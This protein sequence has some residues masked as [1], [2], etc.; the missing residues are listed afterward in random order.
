MRMAVKL[1]RAPPGLRPDSHGIVAKHN[2]LLSNVDLGDFL[3]PHELIFDLPNH[4]IMIPRC[5]VDSLAPNPLPVSERDLGSARA[6]ITQEVEFVCRPSECL[7]WR[8]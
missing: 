1:P 5:E 3:D 4:P 6:E 7:V 2:R 8:P